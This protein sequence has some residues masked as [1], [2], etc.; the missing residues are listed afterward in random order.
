M[1]IVVYSDEEETGVAS[2][3]ILLDFL[4]VASAAV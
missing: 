3:A 2:G 4:R 1:T